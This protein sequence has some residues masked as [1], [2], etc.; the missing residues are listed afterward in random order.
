[1]TRALVARLDSLG[2]VLL[3]GPAVAAVAAGSSHVTL[4]V[5]P[6]GEAAAR[7][8]PGVDEVLVW[9]C[10]WTGY[11]PP[12]YDAGSVDGLVRRLRDGRHDVALVLT[13]DHQSPLPLALLLRQAAVPRIVASSHDYPGS[14]LDLR[15]PAGGPHEVQRNLSLAAAAGFAVPADGAARLAV[16]R[17]LPELPTEVERLRGNGY[18]VVHPAASV[19]ARSISPARAAGIAAAL[20]AAGHDVVVTGRGPEE[21][22]PL[23]SVT[24]PDGAGRVVDLLGRTTLPALASVLAGARCLVSGNTGPA[25]LAAAVGTPVVSLFAPVV[26]AEAWRPWG[27]P[28][29]VLGD[30]QVACAGTRARMCPVPGHPCVDGVSDSEVV[31]AVAR[32]APAEVA[33]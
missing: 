23:P 22:G 11:Q 16:L 9:A 7:L 31:A 24:G 28:T 27:V 8:L 25:H 26:P 14:L 20:A 32:L 2:D 6:E 21:C 17:P 18:V 19:P 5:S 13:S 10:P 29:V 30:Q 12:R 1:M 15:H 3:A 33:A 4:L